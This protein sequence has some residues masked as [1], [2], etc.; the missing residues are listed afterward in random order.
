MQVHVD[1][2]LTLWRVF[3]I[4]FYQDPD[5]V[6]A[7]G[8]I[9]IQTHQGKP[10]WL[11]WLVLQLHLRLLRS[12]ATFFDITSLAGSNNVVPGLA[13]TLNHGNHMI[14]R[15]LRVRESLATVLAGVVV[16]KEDVATV[17]ADYILAITRVDEVNQANDD[18]HPDR[19]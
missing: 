9:D 11:A 5:V 8:Q 6:R 17:Q 1:L 12:P 10:D 19:D 18:W 14:H 3:C 16:S 4:V 13:S 2:I 15:Q 7:V